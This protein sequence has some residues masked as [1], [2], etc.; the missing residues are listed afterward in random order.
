MSN[1][2]PQAPDN[3]QG[4]WAALEGD[5]RT[6][7]SAGNELYIVSGPLGQ[8]GTGSNG[9]TTNTVAN[10]N[11]TVPAYTWKVAL[12]LPLQ[13]GDDISRVTCSTRTIAVLMPNAQGIRSTPWQNFLT[14]VDNIEQLTGFDFFSNLP[15][16]VQACVEAGTN[17]TNPPGTANQTASTTEDNSVTI[18]LTALQSTNASLTF[19]IVNPPAN[20]QLGSVSPSACSNGRWFPTVSYAPNADFNRSES[21]SFKAGDGTTNSNTSTVTIGV[22]EVNDSPTAADDNKSTQEDTPLNFSAGDLTAND[23]AGPANESTQNLTVT[24][25]TGTA[26][27]HGTVSLAS[28]MINYTPAAN[29]NG[30]ASFT[31]TVCDDGTT[32]GA[33]D[34][35][36]ASATVNVTV[37]SV[38][39]NPDAHDDSAVTDEDTPVVVNV[40]ANDSDVDGDA[41]TVSAVTQGAHGSVTNNGNNVTYSPAANYN[42]SD[43][44]SYTVSDGHGG[45]ATANVSVTIKPVN[46]NPVAG[47]DSSTTDEDTPVVVNVLANDSDTNNGSSVTYS[48]AANY[49]GSDSF[50]YTVSDGHGGTATASVNVTINPVNDNPVAIPDSA[51]TNEDNSVTVDVVANDTDVDGDTLS[52]TSVGSAAH[53]S[54]AIVSGKAVYSPAANYNGSDSFGYVVSDGHGGHANGSVSITVNPV[55]DA[56]VANSQSVATTSNTPVGITLTGSDVETA[57][58]SLTFT[59]T[60]GPSH[61]SLMGSG[62][63][64]TYTPAPNYAGPDSFTF[65]VTDTG[66][67][68]SGP[69]TSSEA[70]VSIIVGDTVAPVITLNG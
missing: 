29:Y 41:L 61:G 15:P 47:A 42:G 30:A 48:P 6:I 22:S 3:N 11:V 59:V 37:D 18:T 16:A 67:G 64:R 43:S 23:S 24:S 21:F 26:N 46:D 17:G 34:S 31:Y 19:S 51:T 54:V 28:G 50:T 1:M 38:N 40:L 20:G 5:L 10:G 9:G 56:P 44:F 14:T 8:G 63:N 12:V 4:P 70:T 7:A 60:S 39:D 58:S 25:V 45:T 53:G 57:P 13:S 36:C 33:P 2:V 68:P 27:T 69:L 62:A 55:N 49:N 52:L 65:T 35:K 66:D 32:N